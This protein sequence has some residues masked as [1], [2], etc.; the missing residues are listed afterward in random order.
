MILKVL[1]DVENENLLVL[2]YLLVF[3]ACQKHRLIKTM[4]GIIHHR[5]LRSARGCVRNAPRA[6]D[7]LLTV[8]ERAGQIVFKPTVGT[9]LTIFGYF[10]ALRVSV[11]DA[12]D[13]DQILF[14]SKFINKYNP[15]FNKTVPSSLKLQCRLVV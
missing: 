13:S 6:L 3:D 12:F 2:L 1:T 11:P 5:E 9:N 15:L 10:P 7:L 4:K 14:L 8:Y